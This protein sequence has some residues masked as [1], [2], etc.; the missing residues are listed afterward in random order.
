MWGSALIS[1]LME[2]VRAHRS[3]FI[4]LSADFYKLSSLYL[5]DLLH[6][7]PPSTVL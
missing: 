4:F 6:I 5:L 2:L 1:R 7:A 3:E